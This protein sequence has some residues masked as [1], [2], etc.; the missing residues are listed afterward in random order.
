MAAGLVVAAGTTARAQTPRDPSVADIVDEP[1]NWIGHS[2]TVTDDV[3]DMVGALPF[4]MG[5][6]DFLR[7]F[8]GSEQL[9]VG[10]RE[11]PQWEAHRGER[12]PRMVPADGA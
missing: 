12:R 4:Q 5:E 10:A 9:V 2:V 1:E 8:G 7:L 11:L 6:E 3:T